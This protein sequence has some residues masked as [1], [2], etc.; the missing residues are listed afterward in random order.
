VIC[1]D[2]NF[3]ELIEEY[4]KQKVELLCFLSNYRGGFKVPA[5]AL[6]NQCFVASAVPYE[7]GVIV[8]PLGRKLAES[9]H[10]GRII[11]ARINL[12]SQIVHIDYH[13]DKVRAMKEKYRETVSIETASP[14]AVYFLSSRHPEKSIHDMMDEFAI[15]TLDEYLD[16]ARRARQR[17]LPKDQSSPPP[18]PSVEG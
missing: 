16:R 9:S 2:L 13:T 18:E 7:N 5:I 12:D 17:Y 14:E 8:D 6:R 11:F 15:E 10:Y 4:R 3:D 1:F